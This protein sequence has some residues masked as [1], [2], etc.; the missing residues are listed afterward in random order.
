MHGWINN[1]F[2]LYK[3]VSN[4]SIN[5]QNDA[6]KCVY[7][8][9]IPITERFRKY[10]TVCTDTCAH[11]CSFYLWLC[12]CDRPLGSISVSHF[13]SCV[14]TVPSTQ[15]HLGRLKTI[16]T[17]WLWKITDTSISAAKKAKGTNVQ[18]HH[19]ECQ[20]MWNELHHWIRL[21]LFLLYFKM[22]KISQKGDCQAHCCTNKTTVCVFMLCFGFLTYWSTC[23]CVIH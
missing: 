12:C 1:R 3:L 21:P 22:S 8:I 20:R 15:V 4:K 2:I 7:I 5:M 11:R 16:T 18:S 17:T 23:K 10:C 13:C 14:Q 9:V 6:Q 19:P